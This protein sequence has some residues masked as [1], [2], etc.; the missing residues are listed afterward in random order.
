MRCGNNKWVN[1]EFKEIKQVIKLSPEDVEELRT[2]L[3]QAENY[4]EASSKIMQFESKLE[5]IVQ[6][7]SETTYPQIAGYNLVKGEIYVA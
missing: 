4:D 6:E 2:I 5:S 3:K 1:C 7:A